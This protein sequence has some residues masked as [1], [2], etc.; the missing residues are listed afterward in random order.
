MPGAGESE[1][2]AGQFS[3]SDLSESSCMAWFANWAGA[4]LS[5]LLSEKTCTAHK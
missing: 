1:R 4:K 2:I 5:G 3:C